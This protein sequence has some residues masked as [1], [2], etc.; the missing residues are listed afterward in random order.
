MKEDQPQAALPEFYRSLRAS[1]LVRRLLE[2]ARDEDLGIGEGSGDITSRVS[3]PEG[4]RGRALLVARGG[5]T[6]AGLAVLPDLLD[7]FGASVE[8][9]ARVR[10]G[11]C[12][13][14]GSVLAV[15]SG[16]VAELL[17]LERA[18]LNLIGRLSGVATLTAEFVA[19][20]AGTRA[21]VY[22]TRKTTPGLR[23]LEK[24]AVRCGGGC[25]H[26][27]GLY[28]AVLI[29]DNHIAKVPPAGLPAVVGRAAARARREQ[30]GLLF[31][32][33]EVDT[34][35]QLGQLLTLPPGVIDIILLDN[36]D[37]ATMREAVRMRDASPGGPLLE[38]SGGVRIDTIGAIAATGVERISVGAI[39][40]SASVLDLALDIVAGGA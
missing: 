10:D 28:D 2:L 19:A 30:R 38:A 1:G 24:Y 17:V 34:L 26:R 9:E 33:V 5:G 37:P 35:E 16:P 39:T 14:A 15:L 4:A 27:M 12:V 8:A 31:V 32:E 29:K 23:V 40:H 18:T 22:D 11:E 13:P 7:V 25:S 36:M 21:R 20:V 3:I 6:I